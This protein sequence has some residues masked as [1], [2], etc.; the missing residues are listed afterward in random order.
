MRISVLAAF[1]MAVSSLF[2]F[3]EAKK[4]PR[5]EPDDGKNVPAY[6]NIN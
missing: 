2:V 4:D 6:L 3:E 1:F 5:A